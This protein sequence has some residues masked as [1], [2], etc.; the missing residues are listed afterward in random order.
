MI[1]APADFSLSCS[2]ATAL[3]DPNILRLNLLTPGCS[4]APNCLWM[5]VLW[6]E[7]L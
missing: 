1:H 5:K 3:W 6:L 2:S 4:M 7:V